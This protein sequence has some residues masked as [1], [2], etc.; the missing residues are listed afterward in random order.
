MQAA[1]TP[2]TGNPFCCA[3]SL[4]EVCGSRADVLDHFGRGERAEAAGIS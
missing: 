3:N 2:H 4:S 1:H